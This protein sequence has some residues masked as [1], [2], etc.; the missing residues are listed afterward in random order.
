MVRV[1]PVAVRRGHGLIVGRRLQ[2]VR[3]VDL[4]VDQPPFVC[5]VSGPAQPLVDSLATVGL[6]NPPVVRGRDVV[7]GYRR[8]LAARGLGWDRVTA[9]FV[10]EQELTPEGAVEL[11]LR[12]NLAH[13]S[14]S[15]AEKGRAVDILIRTLGVPPERVRLHFL[16]LLGRA[17]RDRALRMYLNV[18]S[19]TLPVLRLL[20][21][22][23]IGLGTA[24]TLASLPASD[25]QDLCRLLRSVASGVNT[26]REIVE[27]FVD[28]ALRE[29]RGI[30]SVLSDDWVAPSVRSRGRGA[31]VRRLIQQLRL[32][33]QPGYERSRRADL[34]SAARWAERAGALLEVP[35]GREGG[36]W[37]CRIPFRSAADL[38]RKL[39]RVMD[40]RRLEELEGLMGAQG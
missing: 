40:D 24:H 11:A 34:R 26:G 2:T 39:A 1:S 20:D 36:P 3:L 4:V 8:L 15:E 6:I 13:R 18:G 33:R 21:E 16:P 27:G 5:T 9:W 35:P 14:L 37:C 38:R 10:P 30:R 17:P 12:D 25:Q 7:C 19:S 23:R 31:S 22:G 29:E 32:R 28:L